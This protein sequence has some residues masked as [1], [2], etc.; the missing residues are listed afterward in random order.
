MATTTIS[1][2]GFGQVE[3]N[4]LSAQRTSQI[5]AQFQLMVQSIFLKMVSL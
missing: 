5:Y 4:H 1:R 3:P 2:V